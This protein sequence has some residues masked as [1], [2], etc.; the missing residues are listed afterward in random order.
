MPKFNLDINGVDQ[1]AVDGYDVWSGP[2]PKAG[3]YDA[4][5]KVAKIVEIDPDGTKHSKNKGKNRIKLGAELVGNEGDLA[6]YNG[7]VAWGGVNLIESGIGFVNQLL[8]GLTDG[9]EEEFLEIKQ[10]FY[11]GGI[12]V[13]EKKEHITAIGRWKVESPDG[14]L[15]V[16]VTL[17]TRSFSKTQDD[18]T[19]VTRTGIDLAS[20]L[21]RDGSSSASSGG[22]DD[23]PVEEPDVASVDLDDLDDDGNVGEPVD[24]SVFTEDEDVPATVDAG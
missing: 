4:K 16:K 24:E 2:T 5:L 21:V 8:R 20:F 23:E 3:V 19:V 18:G 10:A 12:R 15:P 7:F 22:S 17:K 14:E 6:Q 11:E 1:D 13:D 9:S